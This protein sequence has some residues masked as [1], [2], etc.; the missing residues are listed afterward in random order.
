VLIT[1]KTI[2]RKTSDIIYHNKEEMSADV[3]TPSAKNV[4]KKEFEKNL[5]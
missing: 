4:L 2:P 1:D 3:S 5:K